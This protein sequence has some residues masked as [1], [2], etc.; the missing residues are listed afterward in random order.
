M[1]E[2]KLFESEFYGDN[3]RWFIGIVEKV[4]GDPQKL[5]RVKVR[6]FGV[7]N[8]Y[9]SEISVDDLPWATVMISNGVSGT[10]ESPTG[11]QNGT[12]VFGIFLDGKHSQN[13]I[14]LGALPKIE[15]GLIDNITPQKKIE[16][17][18]IGTNLGASGALSNTVPPTRSGSST[19]SGS[20]DY[21][22]SAGINNG[23]GSDAA[24]IMAAYILDG[25]S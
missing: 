2:L 15:T 10:G 5:G 16:P 21:M 9:L 25:V 7:H 6:A 11:L 19:G 23:F 13:P 20:G 22:F 4:N 8:A 3:I 12:M 17:G 1:S 14:V 18:K 24:A